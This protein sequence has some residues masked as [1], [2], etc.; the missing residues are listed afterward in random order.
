MCTAEVDE[1]RSFLC[2][3]ANCGGSVPVHMQGRDG[4]I[5]WKLATTPVP[6]FCTKCHKRASTS[7]LLFYEQRESE[8]TQDWKKLNTTQQVAPDPDTSQTM[9]V[10]FIKGSRAVL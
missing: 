2:Q 5:H 8:L 4:R 3:E 1:R 6:L 10:N 7:R 9:M